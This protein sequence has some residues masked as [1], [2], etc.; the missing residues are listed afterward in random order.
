MKEKDIRD[1]D[2]LKLYLKLVQEDCKAFLN[3]KKALVKVKCPACQEDKHI[4]EFKK[5][6]F[7]YVTCLNCSTLY[8][9]TRLSFDSLKEF[10]GRSASTDFWVKEFFM[11]VAEARREKIFRPRA[12]F[13]TEYF[14]KDPAWQ[15]GDIGAGFGL[16]LDE[17]HKLWGQ[18]SYIAIEPSLEQAELCGKLDLKAE[19]S[20]LEELKGYDNSFNLL[21]AFELFEHLYDPS[22]FLSS[23]YRL[24]KKGG[25]LFLTTL[26]GEGFDIRILWE[27]SKAIY[28]PCHINFF[29]PGSIRHLLTREGF[30]AVKIETP[31]QL[32][33]DIVEGAIVND[34]IKLGKFW[35]TFARKGKSEAKDE[36]QD[37]IRRN[38]LSSHM[39]VLARKK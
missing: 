30:E 19:C 7:E 25:W 37:W 27:D 16:F 35:E 31:G 33:W 24:L 18:S 13:I 36:L 39:R 8:A 21:T 11:P 38:N 34:S 26:N 12:E 14:G 3:S 5:S 2:K 4:L 29:N 17:L 15:I 22:V 10:Y 28:P 23:V 32:D 1:K 6:C 9:K 20:T